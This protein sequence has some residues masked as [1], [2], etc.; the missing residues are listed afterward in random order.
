MKNIEKSDKYTVKEINVP[1]G[2]TPSYKVNEYTFTITNSDVLA[3]TGQIFYP[4]IITFIVGFILV[5]FGIKTIKE[6]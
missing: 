3:N 2:F 6:A 5:I 4:I 1:K